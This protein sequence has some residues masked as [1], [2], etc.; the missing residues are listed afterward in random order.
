MNVSTAAATMTLA[1]PAFAAAAMASMA[2]QQQLQKNMA[3]ADAQARQQQF[4]ALAAAALAGNAARSAQM[5][6]QQRKPQQP[7]P[8]AMQPGFQLPFLQYSPTPETSS[9]AETR[10]STSGAAFTMAQQQATAAWLNMLGAAGA[11]QPNFGFNPSLGAAA[12]PFAFLPLAGGPAGG[13]MAYMMSGGTPASAQQPFLY[14]INQQQSQLLALQQ[15]AA[16]SMPGAGGPIIGCV[17]E[18]LAKRFT[19]Y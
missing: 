14:P 7:T 18:K 3:S 2:G 15:A 8:T 12:S 11:P 10:S 4:N 17:G 1:N 13:Q 5:V 9:Y 6:P 19:P 16:A